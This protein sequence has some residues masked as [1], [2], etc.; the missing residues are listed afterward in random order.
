VAAGEHISGV[1]Q[2]VGRVDDALRAVPLVDE[3]AFVPFQDDLSTEDPLGFEGY[4][5]A[6]EAMTSAWDE[7]VVAGAGTIAGHKVE[8]AFFNF[9]FLGGSMG[10]VAGERIARAMERAGR[11]GAPFVLHV[12]TGGA[13]MQEGMAALVQMPKV[14]A[15][16]MALAR[17][18]L[19]F[20]AVLAHPSTGGVLASVAALADFTVAEAGATVGF[21]GPRVVEAFTGKAPS[22][23]S[24]RAETAL[25]AGL[26]DAVG[27]PEE[28]ARL[29]GD[30][31]EVMQ[32]DSPPTIPVPEEAVYGGRIEA[33]DAVRAAREP[34]RPRARALVAG[35]S[36]GPIVELRGDRQGGEDPGVVVALV[37][38][39]G[40][41]VVTLA[42]DHAHAPGPAGYRKARRGL[43]LAERLRIPV[44]TIVD[45]R[46]ADP[47]PASE[48][49][50]IAWEIAG[51]FEDLLALPVPVISVVTGEGGSGG[52]LA[53]AA[54]DR[55][56]IYRDAI[57]TVIGPE[58]AAQILW[59][60][61]SKAPEAARLQRLTAHDLQ[62][63]GIADEVVEAGLSPEGLASVLAYHL[64]RL[65]EERAAGRNWAHDRQTRWRNPR[66]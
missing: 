28:V 34:A 29:V 63:L 65:E 60:D 38:I 21:A 42:L 20:A 7:S 33:W 4:R 12:R 15:A 52:A 2:E 8:L 11:R 53:F 30:F 14:V 23:R 5:G 55:L 26:V 58:A 17:S 32:S 9:D 54:A 51:L 3:G 1:E 47:S 61:P 19:P 25:G 31:L 16:R 50:G 66:G 13:R 27:T 49:G 48:N 46:G 62:D 24:H 57:F 56:L 6:V 59:R 44:A 39:S 45:T 37:R 35:L 41:K 18:R 43:A 10:E 36:D 64:A 22:R 40:R